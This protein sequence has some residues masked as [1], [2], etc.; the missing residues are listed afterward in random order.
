V[1]T[2]TSK[3]KKKMLKKLTLLT[4][5]LL[6]GIYASQLNPLDNGLQQSDTINRIVTHLAS[7]E[8]QVTP[9]LNPLEQLQRRQMIARQL[10]NYEMQV[11][12]DQSIQEQQKTT[13]LRALQ[14]GKRSQLQQMQALT[15]QIDNANADE[16][17]INS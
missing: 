5:L 8:M 15:M 3:G 10:T 4:T 17:E 16:E 7:P 2:L 12:M 11:A 9:D 6:G 1:R 14:E 13:L